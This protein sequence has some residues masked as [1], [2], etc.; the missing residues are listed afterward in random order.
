MRGPE[1]RVVYITWRLSWS[2]PRARLPTMLMQLI[3][4]FPY[5]SQRRLCLFGP[6]TVETH[7]PF[8][9]RSLIGSEDG[10]GCRTSGSQPEEY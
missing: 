10:T 3:E 5:L 4:S 2:G 9:R 8:D 6:F 1:S 7:L